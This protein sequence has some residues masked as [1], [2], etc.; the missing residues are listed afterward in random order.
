[1]NPAPPTFLQTLHMIWTGEGLSNLLPWLPAP[2][3]AAL[4]VM[5]K[6]YDPDPNMH[7]KGRVITMRDGCPC[8]K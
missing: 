8:S 1:M 3:R 2:A 4:A 6:R 5:I 7:Q